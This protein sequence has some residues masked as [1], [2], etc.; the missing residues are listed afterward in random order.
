MDIADDADLER[1]YAIAKWLE[2]KFRRQ[3]GGGKKV[4]GVRP[5][6]S[7]PNPEDNFDRFTRLAMDHFTKEWPDEDEDE[8]R[9]DVMAL[10][11]MPKARTR[12]IKNY[13]KQKRGS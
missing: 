13:G 12:I 7:N 3:L 6:P 4:P 11:D 8:L 10:L 2:T 5:T 1:G 9:E